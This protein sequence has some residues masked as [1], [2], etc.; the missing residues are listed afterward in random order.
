MIKL[1][2]IEQELD[3]ALRMLKLLGTSHGE[4]FEAELYEWLADNDGLNEAEWKRAAA[5]FAGWLASTNTCS[6]VVENLLELSK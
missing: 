2:R 5:Y 6:V 4:R 3:I 1:A